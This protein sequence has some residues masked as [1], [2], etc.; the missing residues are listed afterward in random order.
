M[1][2]QEN[3]LPSTVNLDER[4]AYSI[5]R[6]CELFDVGR[7]FVYNEIKAKRLR[8]TKAGGRTLITRGDALRWLED[9]RAYQPNP[10]APRLTRESTPNPAPLDNRGAHK[11]G[12]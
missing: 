6:F 7:S 4:M 5:R 2:D 8:K 3:G 12:S 1:S 10:S 11:P 9:R